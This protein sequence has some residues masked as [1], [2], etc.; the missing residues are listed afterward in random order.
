[1]QADLE[2]RYIG[3][4]LIIAIGA[5]ATPPIIE[6][7]RPATAAAVLVDRI[8]DLLVIVT[9]TLVVEAQGA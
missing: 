2:L 7:V 4:T 6:V 8:I 3:G 9:E 5:E 1:M